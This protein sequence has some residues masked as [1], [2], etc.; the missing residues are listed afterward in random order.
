MTEK[1]SQSERMVNYQTSQYALLDF[2]F[3]MSCLGNFQ[4]VRDILQVTVLMDHPVK[5]INS[6]FHIGRLDNLPLNYFGPII[7]A[8]QKDWH[9]FLEINGKWLIIQ[10]VK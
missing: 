7:V 5:K 10:G 8:I 9:I 4:Y 6:R 3:H 2:I 1:L